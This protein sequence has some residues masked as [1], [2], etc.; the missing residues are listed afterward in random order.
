MK[1]VFNT[2]L[3]VGLYVLL[4]RIR[5]MSCWASQSLGILITD[6]LKSHEMNATSLCITASYLET[7]LFLSWICDKEA[8]APDPV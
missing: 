8:V 3:S 7:G 6:G 1:V 5:A 4:N 2:S